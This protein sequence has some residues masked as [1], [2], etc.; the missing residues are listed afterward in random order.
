MPQRLPDDSE[1]DEDEEIEE[2][3]VPDEEEDEDEEEFDS[4]DGALLAQTG[5]DEERDDADREDREMSG[6]VEDDSEVGGDGAEHGDEPRDAYGELK[7]D[8]DGY[9][10]AEDADEATEDDDEDDEATRDDLGEPFPS[11]SEHGSGQDEDGFEEEHDSDD[12]D[13][14]MSSAAKIPRGRSKMGRPRKQ[15]KPKYREVTQASLWSKKFLA[16]FLNTNYPSKDS[17]HNDGTVKSV[18]CE[19]FRRQILAGVV[20][21]RRSERAEAHLDF[22]IERFV[23]VGIHRAGQTKIVGGRHQPWVV[24]TDTVDPTDTGVDVDRTLQLLFVLNPTNE[25]NRT[26]RRSAMMNP[27]DQLWDDIEADYLDNVT[28]W[29]KMR[30]GSLGQTGEVLEEL[31]RRPETVKFILHYSNIIASDLKIY[32]DQKIDPETR[33]ESFEV[34]FPAEFNLRSWW[35]CLAQQRTW[36]VLLTFYTY[37]FQYGLNLS[38][39]D[40][41]SNR[42]AMKL[43]EAESVSIFDDD[44]MIADWGASLNLK[45]MIKIHLFVLS[46]FGPIASSLWHFEKSNAFWRVFGKLTLTDLRQC[47]GAVAMSAIYVGS[48]FD[49]EIRPV[50]F[51]AG[52]Q[53]AKFQKLQN[54]PEVLNFGESPKDL[55]ALVYALFSTPQSIKGVTAS[56]KIPPFSPMMLSGRPKNDSDYLAWWS[57]GSDLSDVEKDKLTIFA[58]TKTPDVFLIPVNFTAIKEVFYGPNSAAF[59]AMATPLEWQSESKYTNGVPCVHDLLAL[60]NRQWPSIDIPD[61]LVSDYDFFCYSTE[62]VL[63]KLDAL[64]P[65][66]QG[67]DMPW[68][69]EGWDATALGDGE[70]DEMGSWL[71]TFII[72]SK[73]NL[74]RQVNAALP[75]TASR[76]AQFPPKSRKYALKVDTKT[77]KKKKRMRRSLS[78]TKRTRSTKKVKRR[79]GRARHSVSR[80]DQDTARDSTPYAPSDEEM[81]SARTVRKTKPRMAKTAEG[82]ARYRKNLCVEY[83][84]VEDDDDDDEDRFVSSLSLTTA[85]FQSRFKS[86][87]SGV[88]SAPRLESIDFLALFD[89]HNLATGFNL[90]SYRQFLYIR[91]CDLDLAAVKTGKANTMEHL[92]THPVKPE[93]MA[94][95][96]RETWQLILQSMHQYEWATVSEDRVSTVDACIVAISKAEDGTYDR[97][98]SV[99]DTIMKKWLTDHL[100]TVDEEKELFDINPNASWIMAMMRETP[101]YTSMGKSARNIK[102]YQRWLG[103]DLSSRLSP[104]LRDALW[105]RFYA[106]FT[107]AVAVNHFG[108]A[109]GIGRTRIEGYAA[110]IAESLGLYSARHVLKTIDKRNKLGV[111]KDLDSAFL[112]VSLDALTTSLSENCAGEDPEWGKTRWDPAEHDGLVWKHYAELLMTDLS[113]VAIEAMTLDMEMTAA[114]AVPLD[115]LLYL[116]LAEIA[117]WDRLHMQATSMDYSDETYK[118]RGFNYVMERIFSELKTVLV[119]EP[120]KELMLKTDPAEH[121]SSCVNRF[122]PECLCFCIPSGMTDID[123]SVLWYRSVLKACEFAINWTKLKKTWLSRLITFEAHRNIPGQLYFGTETGETTEGLLGHLKFAIDG[124]TEEMLGDNNLRPIATVFLNIPA[125]TDATLRQQMKNLTIDLADLKENDDPEF[126]NG[127]VLTMVNLMVL[128]QP[129]QWELFTQANTRKWGFTGRDLTWVYDWLKADAGKLKRQRDSRLWNA[130]DTNYAQNPWC[131]F[132]STR[133]ILGD[134][135]HGLNEFY[136]AMIATEMQVHSD[137]VDESEVKMDHT[138]LA[139]KYYSATSPIHEECGMPR[140]AIM[141]QDVLM[142]ANEHMMAVEDAAIL[143]PLLAYRLIT[144]TTLEQ[145]EM[146]PS[147]R[148]GALVPFRPQEHWVWANETWRAAMTHIGH[149]I[150]GYVGHNWKGGPF[151]YVRMSIGELKRL[152]G[153]FRPITRAEVEDDML[154]EGRVF[155]TFSSFNGEADPTNLL[156]HRI[157]AVHDWSNVNTHLSHHGRG[158]ELI[159]LSDRLHHCGCSS[160]FILQKKNPFQLSLETITHSMTKKTCKPREDGFV[161]PKGL[162]L[163][164]HDLANRGVADPHHTYFRDQFDLGVPGP[165]STVWMHWERIAPVLVDGRLKTWHFEDCTSRVRIDTVKRKDEQQI[166]GRERYVARVELLV[167]EDL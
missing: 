15:S 126:Y 150:G 147:G 92:V 149:W 83:S 28:K 157:L 100:E 65:L 93:G 132:Q 13:V 102:V 142:V 43:M 49:F 91:C 122:N 32:T 118:F 11:S 51:G 62:K 160:S 136:L 80:A 76:M 144:K 107:N 30:E 112:T 35:G 125:R 21:Q 130:E 79:T 10:I 2:E 69:T 77:V 38:Y 124:N 141:A 82:R 75:C 158:R 116:L 63:A 20:A 114:R 40:Y 5:H 70:Y 81:S 86:V 16:R 23:S 59:L 152:A 140:L 44:E 17:K 52:G 96:I 36:M 161:L 48:L 7:T 50:A 133:K 163:I 146:V 78:P 31:L 22:V 84:S 115:Y 54:I 139:F 8:R 159:T 45:M 119:K 37:L 26:N 25:T 71:S 74:G 155:V 41:V 154:M 19:I 14:V 99:L 123:S 109:L 58:M 66:E 42:S 90:D 111:A 39:R 89:R 88:A 165:H 60:G 167:R 101:F 153:V 56:R 4:D 57:A 156:D 105:M 24:L 67:V 6:D 53:W 85:P 68:R 137:C 18:L 27:R 127:A 64:I 143:S 134:I 47:L 120:E 164:F 61:A 135:A 166:S 145:R 117:R 106:R 138:T 108:V 103:D 29:L 148:D 34:A 12:E 151:Q 95:E 104:K 121:H 33:M 98:Q 87:R 73:F 9:L 128:D 113:D 72:W 110:L 1:S 55:P 131:L 3:M 94:V 46:H 129:A 97:I 162:E